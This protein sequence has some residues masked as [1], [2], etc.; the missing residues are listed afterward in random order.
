MARIARSRDVTPNQFPSFCSRR[1]PHAP[2]SSLICN[3]FFLDCNCVVLTLTPA[4]M[5]LATPS[6]LSEAHLNLEDLPDDLLRRCVRTKS[7][8][9][10]EPLK[11]RDSLKSVLSLGMCNKNLR[12]LVQ[13]GGV[14]RELKVQMEDSNRNELRRYLYRSG[15]IEIRPNS[16]SLNWLC[17]WGPLQGPPPESV[18]FTFWSSLKNVAPGPLARLRDLLSPPAATVYTHNSRAGQRPRWRS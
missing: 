6:P 1:S 18:H 3:F 15:V 9:Q 4:P 13:G 8:S 12:R 16:P 2:S 17:S 10:T 5:T 11:L 14:L 7:L